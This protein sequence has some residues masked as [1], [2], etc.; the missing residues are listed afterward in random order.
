MRILYNKDYR[1]ILREEDGTEREYIG[2]Y[3]ENNLRTNKR[4]SDRDL[5]KTTGPGARFLGTM[6]DERER[7]LEISL[8]GLAGRQGDEIVYVANVNDVSAVYIKDLADAEPGSERH[9]LHGYAR[10]IKGLGL[11]A[12]GQRAAVAASADGLT[13]QIT[14]LD[15]ASGDDRT[16]TDGDIVADNPSFSG[17][18]ILFNCYLIGRDENGNFAG[19]SE[20][21][22]YKLDPETLELDEI[23]KKEGLN[24]VCPKTDAAGNLYYLTRPVSGRRK[25]SNLFLDIVLFPYRLIKAFVNF[26]NIFSV[27]YGGG[28]LRTSD[29]NPAKSVQKTNKEL[30]IEGNR[31]DAERN[32][33]ENAKK[34][35]AH[36]GILPRTWQLLK[37]TP[38]GGESVLAKGVLAYDVDDAGRV[39]YSNGRHLFLLEG[40]EER[41]L[42]ACGLA[43]QVAI[44]DKDRTEPCGK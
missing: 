14:L 32:L 27:S 41:H 29:G 16:L 13:W 1:F 35:S 24:C 42:C 43:E 10:R 38:E 23:L 31:I 15:L 6:S 9:I 22:L 2:E 17:E 40:G 34:G 19:Y 44:L 33:R 18:K 8:S 26:L 21:S 20:S 11:D 7:P 37:V 3:I 28:S 25:K 4:L 12:A 39:V 30:F 5:W 36:P